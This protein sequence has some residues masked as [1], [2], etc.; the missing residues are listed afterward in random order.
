M[1]LL[2]IEDDKKT[3]ELLKRCLEQDCYVVDWVKEGGKGSYMA[4]IN[5]YDLIILD[6]VLPEKNGKTIC[7]EIRSEDINTPIIMLTIRFETEDKVNL[8]ESG[9]DDYLTKPYSYKEL[10]ARIKAILRRK[11]IIQNNTIKIKGLSI[12]SNKNKVKYNNVDI[13]FRRKEFLLLKYLAE[14]KGDVLSRGDLIEHVWDM[15]ADAFSNTI[16]THILSIRKK[17]EKITNIKF[18]IT[19]PGRGY[20]I[21]D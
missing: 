4:R 19:V 20:K 2:L 16:E 6:Y 1:K 10:K 5:N 9:I 21:C 8:F 18:I 3:G 12:N 14:N 11:P 17:L 15:N 7:E 13:Y